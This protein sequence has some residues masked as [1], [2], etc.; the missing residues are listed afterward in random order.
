MSISL[1]QHQ[2]TGLEL[3]RTHPRFHF[4]W[5]PGTGKTILMLAIWKERPA[6]TLVVAQ[7]SIIKTAWRKDAQLMGVPCTVAYD[8]NKKRRE[9]LLRTP[10]HGVIV[11]NY[12]QFKMNWKMLLELGFERVI[13]DESSKLKNRQSQV[14]TIA[15]NFADHMREVYLLSGTPAPNCT[16]ELWSQLRVLHPNAVGRN[17]FSWAY[18]W[19]IPE[20][21]FVRGK[22][23][24]KGWKM[25][26]GVDHRFNASLKDWMWALRKQDC[27]DLPETTNQI[28]AVDLSDAERSAYDKVMTDLKITVPNSQGMQVAGVDAKI[29]VEGAAMK[30]RQIVGGAVLVNDSVVPVGSTKLDAFMEWVE[31]LGDEQA[32]VWGEFTHEIDR[33]AGRLRSAGKSVEIIDGRNSSDSG[34]V[35]DNF[36]AKRTQFIVAHPKAAGHGTDG[37]QKVCQYAAYVSLSYSSESHEQSRDRLHRK[38]QSRPCTFV[39]FLATD[40]ID[41]N[42]LLCVQRKTTKQDVLL[43]ELNRRS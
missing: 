8:T 14:T 26:S 1:M 38:G 6:R 16:T 7:R 19:F 24:I 21:D 40:T 20:Y 17:F 13:F 29:A 5:K 31:E 15:T 23:L 25:K 33:I 39:Y 27:M 30:L 34:D 3:S 43:A 32:V 41:E 2:Q 37:L 10:G 11:T 42:L 18:E 4:A 22:R 9:A 28:I 36:V 12:E 35:V